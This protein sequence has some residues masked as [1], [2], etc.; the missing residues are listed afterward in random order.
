M[1]SVWSCV[2]LLMSLFVST[3]HTVSI[4]SLCLS[5]PLSLSLSLSLSLLYILSSCCVLTY[6]AIISKIFLSSVS[7]CL[8]L[9]LPRS[10]S[11]CLPVCRSVYLFVSTASIL[12]TNHLE[13]V[14]AFVSYVCSVIL[15]H[16]GSRRRI[17]AVVHA[18]VAIL[19]LLG[20]TDLRVLG[21]GLFGLFSAF[22]VT[23]GIDF[24]AGCAAG[25][26]MGGLLL[27]ML[28]ILLPK[29]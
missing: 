17:H 11:L 1:L 26:I 25:L 12:S 16:P 21:S 20:L 8:S 24:M 5:V 9:C 7:L 6:S 3:V 10:L 22:L 28:T 27:W 14:I 15:A 23:A 2:S 18:T 19:R 13:V 4:L 29:S